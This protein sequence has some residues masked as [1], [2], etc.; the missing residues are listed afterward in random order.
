MGKFLFGAVLCVGLVAPTFAG[1]HKVPPDEPIVTVQVP[2]KWK[3]TER[4]EHIEAVSPDGAVSFLVMTAEAKKINEAMGEAMRYLRNKGGITV[5]ADSVKHETGQLNGMDVKNISW[6][7][8]NQKGD[9]TINFKIMSVPEGKP[10]IVAYWASLEAE[11]KH[12][13]ELNKMM[14]S[15]TRI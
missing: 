13:K 11:K 5:R 4:G 3:T 14:Q 7:G 9:V 8:K 2:D 10:V 15:I 1:T 12:Q 6:Q